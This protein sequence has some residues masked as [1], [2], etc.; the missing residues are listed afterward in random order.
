[1]A[2]TVPR[3]IE[4]VSQGAL[5][6]SKKYLCQLGD[7]VFSEQSEFMS[8]MTG[9]QYFVGNRKTLQNLQN[10]FCHVLVKAAHRGVLL[11]L[12]AEGCNKDPPNGHMRVSSYDKTS[13][14]V[15]NG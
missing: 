8:L 5:L 2:R 10:T 11:C 9:Y 4:T 6:A 7:E 15:K 12:L 1:M 14:V 3:Q 13:N